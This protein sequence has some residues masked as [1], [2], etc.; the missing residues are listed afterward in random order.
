MIRYVG[1]EPVLVR[2]REETGFQYDP[3]EIRR[4][5]GPK[6]RG[7]I[8]CSPSNPTG[9][10]TPPAL[11]EE[12]ASLGPTVVSDEIYHGMTYEGEDHTILEYT[13]DAFVLNGFSKRWAM[14]GWRLGWVAAPPEHVRPMQ[15]LQ[16][17][18]FISP[19]G[20][21]QKAGIA[22]LTE[23]HPELPEMM[24][25]YDKRRR[26]LV[27]ALRALGLSIACDPGGAFY[28]F[29]GVKDFTDDCYKFAFEILEKARVAVTP[30]VD[31]GPGSEGYIRFSY[32]NSLERLQEG[33]RRLD[34]FLRG[35]R[36]GSI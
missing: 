9:C 32:A 25:V 3:D 30:G 4:R 5:L 33:V 2:V 23:T 24:A 22:A 35:R 17:N 28:V 26:F 27:P 13:D 18:F 6:T 31:F 34:A 10:V 15:K 21:V 8:V 36:S 16:Q 1:G 12:I 7:I 14:T 11:L 19:A 20:F 29:A